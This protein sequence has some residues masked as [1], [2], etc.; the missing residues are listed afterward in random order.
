M[1]LLFSS[2]SV[3]FFCRMIKNKI[4][5]FLM[6]NK[7]SSRCHRLACSIASVNYWFLSL[8]VSLFLFSVRQSC[9]SGFF[10]IFWEEL[11]S[12]TA[13]AIKI[14]HLC[15]LL[16]M[17]AL[18]NY[19]SIKVTGNRNVS[20]VSKEMFPIFCYNPCSPKMSMPECPLS[21]CYCRHVWANCNPSGLASVVDL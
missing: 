13:V 3:L 12:S 20:S 2:R 19:S 10:P 6:S 21:C 17:W 16:T 1:L 18:K 11:A 15:F 4:I 9:G 7:F 14:W 8:S 5:T